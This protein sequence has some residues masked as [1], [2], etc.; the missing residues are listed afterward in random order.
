MGDLFLHSRFVCLF[1]ENC[2]EK[3][4][5]N[6]TSR[7]V[8]VVYSYFISLRP[9]VYTNN[10]QLFPSIQPTLCLVLDHA[11]AVSLVNFLLLLILS[12][13]TRLLIRRISERF[14][15][16]YQNI[17]HSSSS[18]VLCCTSSISSHLY[19]CFSDNWPSSSMFYSTHPI[20]GDVI[21]EKSN[22]SRPTCNRARKDSGKT[23][24]TPV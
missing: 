19:A 21:V 15:S 16:Y 9:L 8:E 3:R 22:G 12:I 5:K 13:S 10:I 18:L 20:W 4:G 14:V 7:L 6:S 2:E 17:Y 24:E 11:R 23:R 1:F